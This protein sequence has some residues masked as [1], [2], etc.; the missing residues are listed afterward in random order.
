M[1]GHGTLYSAR[2]SMYVSSFDPQNNPISELRNRGTL[3]LNHLPSESL[4]FELCVL[5]PV[6]QDFPYT[7]SS[8]ATV[9]IRSCYL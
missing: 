4:E 3:R 6:I 9:L 7:I 8:V 5:R 2:L 1:H